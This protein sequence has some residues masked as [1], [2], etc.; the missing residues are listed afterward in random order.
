MLLLWPRVGIST[1]ITPS[2][3]GRNK[4]DSCATDILS[5]VV[6]LNSHVLGQDQK[7]WHI[8]P[9]QR[10][11]NGVATLGDTCMNLKAKNSTKAF[12]G[13]YLTCS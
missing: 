3:R 7:S 1:V 4:G 6:G 8:S 2:T 10:C 12:R 9:T 11:T 5:D 13:Y